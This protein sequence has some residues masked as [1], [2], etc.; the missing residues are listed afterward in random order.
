L[1]KELPR[2]LVH[3]VAD[4]LSQPGLVISPRAQRGQNSAIHVIPVAD[5]I[6]KL[7][8]LGKLYPENVILVRDHGSIEA[9]TKTG[10]GFSER[11]VI[12]DGQA[13]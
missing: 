12:L 10:K 4:I 3:K 1:A 7:A 9:V 11:F 5:P 8:L 2:T 6:I 13:C